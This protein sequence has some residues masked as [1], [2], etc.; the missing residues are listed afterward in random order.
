MVL[1]PKTGLIEV[2]ER[3]SSKNTVCFRKKLT[4]K[5]LKG[6]LLLLAVAAV[7][8][9]IMASA[10]PSRGADLQLSI[11]SS[12]STAGTVVNSVA[13][14]HNNAGLAN[15]GSATIEVVNFFGPAMNMAGSEVVH[16]KIEE[17]Y[18]SGKFN[19]NSGYVV[20]EDDKIPW[21]ALCYAE[22]NPTKWLVLQ[23]LIVVKGDSVSISQISVKQT[24]NP[25]LLDDTYGVGGLGYGPAA[26]G[27]KSDGSRI[28]SGS[29][30]QMAK[31]V[32]FVTQMKMFNMAD[33]HDGQATVRNYL[34]GHKGRLSLT[35]TASYGISVITTTSVFVIMP[36]VDLNITEDQN[37][38]KV[39]K[40]SIIGDA[41]DFGY[42]LYQSSDPQGPW[43]GIGEIRSLVGMDIERELTYHQFFKALPQR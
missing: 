21:T 38:R 43:T 4:M 3:I 12:S 31:T 42:N 20:I 27:V 19:R 24:S 15:N 14:H 10:L 17:D 7:M 6:I 34:L 11:G 40:I 33:S 5:N 18:I 13:E 35:F 22:G 26:I 8:L 41:P 36:R 25:K 9:L 39:L 1:L 16:R 28:E 37:F 23:Q 29:G 2:L 30:T 32:L